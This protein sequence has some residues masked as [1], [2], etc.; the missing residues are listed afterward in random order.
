MATFKYFGR[1]AQGKVIKGELDATTAEAVAEQLITRGITPTDIHNVKKKGLILPPALK[2]YFEPKV[3][4]EELVAFSRQMYTLSKSGVP[5]LK[6]LGH[7]A[8]TTR[9][10]RMEDS[11]HNVIDSI[12]EGKTF[13]QS[14]SRHPEIFPVIFVSLIEAGENSGQ[15][16]TAFEQLTS[17][18]EL[19]ASTIKKIKTVMRYPITVVVTIFAALFVINFWVIP[20]F[21]LMFKQ[22]KTTLPL[23]TRILIGSSNFCLNYWPY[24]LAVL[25]VFIILF[26]FLLKTKV[27]RYQWDKWLLKIPGIG[28]IIYRIMLSR[29]SR[30]FALMIKT[31]LPIV[32]GL[33]LAAN[34]VNNT[35]VSKSINKM[36]DGIER[37]ENLTQTA[38]E[39]ELFDPL[40]LQMISVGEEAGSVDTLLTEVANYY[41]REV[42]YD[43]NRLSA[44]MEPILLVFMGFMVLILALGVFLPM[45]DMVKF[46]KS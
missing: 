3:K 10:R 27:G 11:L 8:E 1:D 14:L 45:W 16:D 32:K 6:A 28:K 24:M 36:R 40:V 4:I 13:S 9:S 2:K 35:Y 34:I 25:I 46:I 21:A 7:I 15:M 26:R 44:L 42:D 22:F 37:G 20:N 39:S 19:E 23:P 12:A 41:E 5:I 38:N 30:T 43:L 29:F 33:T 17:Y 18:L 31:G